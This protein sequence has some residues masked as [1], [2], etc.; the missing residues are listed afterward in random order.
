MLKKQY[1]KSRKIAKITFELGQTEIPEELEAEYVTLVGEFND[2]D[3][4]A[5]P[6][7]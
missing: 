6:M 3:Q 2:W 1:V 5:T 7:K 4:V